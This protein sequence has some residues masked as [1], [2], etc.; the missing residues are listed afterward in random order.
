MK[1]TDTKIPITNDIDFSQKAD[2]DKY[3]PK[4]K[5]LLLIGWRKLQAFLA[6]EFWKINWKQISTINTERNS[7]MN[8]AIMEVEW[9]FG[10]RM[11]YSKV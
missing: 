1:L 5:N 10:N 7:F 3:K 8:I 6:S 2:Y 4:Q 9:R 11:H